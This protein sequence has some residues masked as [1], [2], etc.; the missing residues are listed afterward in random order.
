[1]QTDTKVEANIAKVDF[2][3]PTFSGL[4]TESKS[5]STSLLKFESVNSSNKNG[6][7]LS[8]LAN[9]PSAKAEDGELIDCGSTAAGTRF[10]WRRFKT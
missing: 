5:E 6:F 2:R 4:E 3:A 7:S 9:S 8:E 1:M 10:K